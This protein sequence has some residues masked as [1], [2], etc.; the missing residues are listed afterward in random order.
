MRT[1]LPAFEQ[2]TDGGVQFGVQVRKISRSL[3]AVLKQIPNFR[4]AIKKKTRE[5]TAFRKYT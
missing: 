1:A 5:D 2:G 3:V 4:L